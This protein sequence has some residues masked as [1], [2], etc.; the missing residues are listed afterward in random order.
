ML[1][2]PPI[3]TRTDTL[4]PYT[5][6]F[7]STALVLR[8]RRNA[9][10]S[11]ALPARRPYFHEQQ[12]AVGDPPRRRAGLRRILSVGRRRVER[13]GPDALARVD[14]ALNVGWAEAGRRAEERRGGK[15][16]V[17]TCRSRWSPCH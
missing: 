10:R 14:A 4:F 12:A 8:P 11:G 9:R 13:C 15:E 7:R 3:S 2:L 16:C 17:S 1:L 5:T 6:R